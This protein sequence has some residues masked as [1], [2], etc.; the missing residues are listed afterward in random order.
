[1]QLLG[2]LKVGYKNVLKKGSIDV[3]ME[4]KHISNL[5]CS[6]A[7]GTITRDKLL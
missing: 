4:H 5:M 3:N 2:S 7:K 1:M 6:K